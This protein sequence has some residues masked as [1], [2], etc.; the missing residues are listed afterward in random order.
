MFTY[1]PLFAA[2]NT[3]LVGCCSVHIA[4][5]RVSCRCRRERSIAI[6]S[7]SLIIYVSPRVSIHFLRVWVKVFPFANF[8][9]LLVARSIQPCR[10]PCV[11][12]NASSPQHRKVYRA[13]QTQ[14]RVWSLCHPP[15]LHA[16][17]LPLSNSNL[18]ARHFLLHALYAYLPGVDAFEQQFVITAVRCGCGSLPTRSLHIG[19]MVFL[20]PR[21]G[22]QAICHRPR[23]PDPSRMHQS[24]IRRLVFF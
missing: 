4:A 6:A 21:Q 11:P 7:P 12:F 20:P 15:P 18:D 2:A 8:S 23:R 10:Q 14:H 9:L 13:A 3:E 19:R 24:H 5:R 1:G 17:S 22:C 16:S